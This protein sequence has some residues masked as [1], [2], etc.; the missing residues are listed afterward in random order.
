MKPDKVLKLGGLVLLVIAAVVAVSLLADDD[1]DNET[2][3][4]LV[5]GVDW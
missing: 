2:Y 3:K 4:H 5:R 1:T